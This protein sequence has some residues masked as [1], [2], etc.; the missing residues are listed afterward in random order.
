MGDVQVAEGKWKFRDSLKQQPYEDIPQGFKPQFM[1]MRNSNAMKIP[2]A[3]VPTSDED[4]KGV[5]KG[6]DETEGEA[7]S[8]GEDFREHFKPPTNVTNSNT[9]RSDSDI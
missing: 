6:E 9:G 4:E 3:R 5:G 7:K 1:V 8:K 2:E